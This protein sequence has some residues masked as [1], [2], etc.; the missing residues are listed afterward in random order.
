MKCSSVSIVGRPSSGKST[1]LNTVCER[2]VAITAETPQTTRNPIKGIYSDSRGQLIFTDTP[3]YHLSD[4]AFNKRLQDIAVKTLEENELVLYMVDP[5]RPAGA[6]EKEIVSILRKVRLPIICCINKCDSA[7][8]KQV[9]ETDD[10]LRTVLPKAVVLKASALK[11]E[12][13][14]EVLIELFKVAHEG[15]MMFDEATFTDRDLE[16][17]ISEIIREKAIR[18]FKNELP[19]S[20]FVEIADLEYNAEEN[21]TWIRAFIN[22]EKESQKGIVVGKGGEMI[23]HI[24]QDAFKEIRSIFPGQKI[25]VDIRVKVQPKW[26]KN[27]VLLDRML[28]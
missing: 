3:G 20:I 13:I 24:R 19:H 28:N 1:F 21:S 14:D 9:Q 10:F 18:R 4:K 2:K 12:G 8:A 26:Q 23:K 15:P 16:F 5:L 11:D 27:S 25:M 22:V 7:S 6:E 17:R